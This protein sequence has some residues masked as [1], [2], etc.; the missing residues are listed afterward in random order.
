MDPFLSTLN[1]FQGD[2]KLLLTVIYDGDTQN[3]AI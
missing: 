1:D 2:G 3:E